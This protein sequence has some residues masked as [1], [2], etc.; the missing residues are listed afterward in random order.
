MP[1]EADQKIFTRLQFSAGL[2]NTMKLVSQMPPIPEKA[3]KIVPEFA[4]Y[5]EAL[6]KW[7]ITV[8][9]ALRGGQGS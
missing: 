6:K 2:D 7:Q 9:L 8:I 1:S 3:K 5:E 4:D